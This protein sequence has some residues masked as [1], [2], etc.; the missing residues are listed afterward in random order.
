MRRVIFLYGAFMP[1]RQKFKSTCLH[2]LFASLAFVSLE[3]KLA[4]ANDDRTF[5]NSI[6]GAW[7]GPGKIVAG[8]Y[9]GTKFNCQFNGTPAKK[10]KVGINMD[11]TCRVGVF[12]QQMNATIL[13]KGARYSGQF[14]DG[15][16]G[17]GLDIVSGKFNQSKAVVGI[18]RKQLNGAMVAELLD[19]NRM[20]VTVSVKVGDNMV[21]VIGMT[22]SRNPVKRTALVD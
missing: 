10:N 1:T 5:F 16:K 3:T 4:L 2:L 7:Q 15:A 21:P 13:K 9:K 14:L 22:L 19:D 6:E 18:N 20:N 11:G 17:E 12:N 8:K